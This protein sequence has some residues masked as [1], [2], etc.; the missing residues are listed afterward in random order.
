[1]LS[2]AGAWLL[3]WIALFWLWML[4]AGDWNHI[5][6]I[7]GACAATVAATVAEAARR[8]GAL[9]VRVPLEWIARGWSVPVLVV[10]DFGILVWVLLECVLRRR[11]RRGVFRAHAFSVEGDVPTAVGS[12][13][14]VMML[15]TYSPNA[16]VVDFDTERELVLLHD[17]VPWQPSESPA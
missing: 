12:R 11:V 17:L 14:A 4:L 10:V 7:A 2:R 15:A 6:W 8:V 5:E 3:W 16:Y 1:M 9:R 13:A